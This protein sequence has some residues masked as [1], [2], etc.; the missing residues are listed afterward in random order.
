MLND[1]NRQDTRPINVRRSVRKQDL[2]VL[3]SLQAGKMMP[4]AAIPL[5]REDAV[6]R[7]SFSATFEM[8]ET[9]EVLMNPV[10]MTVS[11]YLFPFLASERFEGSMDQFNRSYKGQPKVEGGA[12]E[13]WV[14]LLEV[15]EGGSAEVDLWKYLGLH[16][17]AGDEVS[18]FYNEAYVS[19][20]NYRAKNRSQDIELVESTAL[21]NLLPAFWPSSR[22]S[23]IVPDFD[24]AKMEGAIPLT[25]IDGKMPVRNYSGNGSETE[26]N[27]N[28]PGGTVFLKMANDEIREFW[29]SNDATRLVH[30]GPAMTTAQKITDVGGFK[31]DLTEVFAE[32]QEDGI[33]ISLA[34]IEVA[35]KTQAYA[36][37]RERY[38]GLDEEWVIDMLMSGLSIPD[39]AYKQPIFLGQTKTTFQFGK[40]YSTEADALD[41]HVVN[42]LAVVNMTF[43]TPRI[44]TG[45]VI[46]IV[47]EV[48][49]EQLFERQQDPLFHLEKAEHLPEYLR[50][51]MDP[52]KVVVVPND[53]IDTDHETPDGLFGYAP[54]NHQWATFGPRIG[55]RFYRP[56]VDAAEDTDRKRLWAVETKN[57]KLAENFYIVSDIH[58]KPFL[59][60]DEDPVDCMLLGQVAIEGNTV[61]GGALIEASDDYSRVLEHVETQRIEKA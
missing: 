4:L 46:M 12:V 56:D 37:I 30:S 7:G 42:G 35:K 60:P 9:E 36:R 57:P 43:R 5:L 53:Y 44:P 26:L 16:A 25:F 28:V 3:T 49:P 47:G 59:H 19:I 23:H 54:L 22:F 39:Q 40:R 45:G 55:G 41:A 29:A 18:S 58:T 11:A 1:R 50:D 31:A 32:L 61:F 2:T 21:G 48:V 20:W 8:H 10:H 14:E 51:D 15:P 6:Q 13:P 27:S 52:E 33:S 17:S 34:N 38:Q 24:Q